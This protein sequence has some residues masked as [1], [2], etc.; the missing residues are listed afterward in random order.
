VPIAAQL[1]ALRSLLPARHRLGRPTLACVPPWARKR[2]TRLRTCAAFWRMRGRTCVEGAR[3]R[4]L[5]THAPDA[6]GPLSRADTRRRGGDGAGPD[7]LRRGPAA[8]ARVWALTRV[9]APRR[10]R[11]RRLPS[12][13]MPC[14]QARCCRG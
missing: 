9:R 14:C 13:P 5:A 3:V 10:H 11:P 6:R 8:G 12:A 2:L 1:A 4:A 7:R